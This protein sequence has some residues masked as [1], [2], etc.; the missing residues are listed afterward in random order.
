MMWS[1]LGRICA[2]LRH[3]SAGGVALIA[4]LSLPVVVGGLG[5]AV[6][7]GRGLDER[8]VTQRVAD[9]AALGAALA[10]QTS[11]D[12]A[13]LTAIARDLAIGNGLQDADVHAE[14]V[15]DFPN[16]GDQ[17]VKVVITKQ[18]PFILA[19]IVGA[20]ATFTVGSEAVAVVSG[21]QPFAPPCFLALSSGN[22]ALRTS[23]GGT[24]DA[25]DCSVAA[26]GQINNAGSLI[27][28]SDIISG[29]GQI[30][31]DWGT[32]TASSLRFATDFSNP[33][34]NNAVPAAD[35]RVNQSTALA[36]PW[37]DNADLAAA[38]SL[39]G[40]FTAI[41]NLAN[42][43]TAS[44]SNWDF[45]WSPAA[46]VAAFRAGAG[47]STYNVPAGNYTIGQL[48]VAGGIT[49]NFASGSTITIN[50]GFS[51]GGSSVVFGDVNLF[52][53]G[54]FN[55]G[56]SGI[57]IGNGTLHIGSGT[58]N[59]SGTNIKGDGDVIVNAAITIG[60][61]S[62][63]RMGNGQHMFRSLSIS[64]GSFV[65][66][67]TGNFQV[68]E[69]IDVGGNSE[70]SFGNGNVLIGPRANG[71]AISLAGS[72]RMFMGDGTFSA[73]GHIVTQGGSRIRFPATTNHLINGNMT[74]AGS[75]LFDAGRYTIAGNFTN[76]T[77]GTVWPFTS[78]HTGITWGQT[79]NGV[80]ASG[81]DMVGVDVTFVL[82]G[83]LNLAGGARTKLIAPSSSVPGG[84]IREML[85]HSLTS[86]N[87]SWAAGSQSIFV[88]TVHVPNS[89]LTMSG[90]STNLSAG[91]CFTVIA[92]TIAATGGAAAG[93]ACRTMEEAYGGGGSGGDVI[94][95]VR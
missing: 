87:T 80:T 49:V 78:P 58:V 7:L 23:G 10:Y 24:F 52:V 53:N 28:A 54:G 82:S 21:E 50:N 90:G 47:S 40:T 39:I 89:N 68:N 92:N 51:N 59:F 15:H 55:S 43:T 66:A 72:G 11:N 77:G 91:Q 56:S 26:V 88:G 69:G 29:A 5:L 32:L 83:T 17:A 1:N 46:N 45:N 48:N 36:D 27:R 34:W 31:N 61:G 84:Q 13:N 2:K 75:A 42:P 14:L 16:S 95:L 35:K 8:M 57:R 74:I 85:L 94:R 86:A 93:S 81:F 44:A 37:A 71:N 33:S 60:G 25:P 41:S 19:R 30:R 67:G 70:L 20:P 73:N 64:G 38:R 79:L 18:L 65:V 63:L 22:D 12:A 76:G 6:D 3:D 9:S 62:S 4:G